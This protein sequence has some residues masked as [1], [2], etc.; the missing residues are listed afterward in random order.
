M[1]LRTG[2]DIT[3]FETLDL[4]Y[5]K[6]FEI[7]AFMDTLARIHNSCTQRKFAL[8]ID[9]EANDDSKDNR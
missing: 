8:G 1:T 2:G 4:N 7:F 5:L 6:I 9:I 3:S